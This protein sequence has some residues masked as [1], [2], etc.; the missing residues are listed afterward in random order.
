MLRS[1][2]ILKKVLRYRR[3]LIPGPLPP[4]TVYQYCYLSTQTCRKKYLKPK[5]RSKST[6][7]LKAADPE[8]LIEESLPEEAPT[9]QSA[10]GVRYQYLHSQSSIDR[11][12][13]G[14]AGAT[15]RAIKGIPPWVWVTN[16]HSQAITVVV[17]Q[18]KPCRIVT[19]S[20]ISAS[21]TGGGIDVEAQVF[22]LTCNPQLRII[23]YCEG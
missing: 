5:R 19:K 1:Y 2:L 7:S 13:Q 22:P 23:M 6:I 12:V 16:K 3:R 21:T 4:E 9:F 17:S 11:A 14:P 8:G 18:F 20:G 15:A 10:S